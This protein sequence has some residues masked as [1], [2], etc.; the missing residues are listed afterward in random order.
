MVGRL[1]GK[2]GETIKGLQN[3]F[4]VSIQIDQNTDPCNVTITGPPHSVQRAEMEVR[5]IM[6]GS[7]GPPTA[8]G[9]GG[10][11][12]G[13]EWQRNA[14]CMFHRTWLCDAGCGCLA[15]ARCHLACPTRCAVPVT[16]ALLL[17]APLAAVHSHTMR[18]HLCLEL[19][20]V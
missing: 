15:A 1:I 7:Y 10:F 5:N 6:S 9:P 8:G 2:G 3:Q 13:G 12:G 17:L 16:T 11:G 18:Q 19:P 4:R 20:V 14:G